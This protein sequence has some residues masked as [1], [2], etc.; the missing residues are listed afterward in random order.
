MSFVLKGDEWSSEVV[1]GDVATSLQMVLGSASMG[2][3]ALDE[4]EDGEDDPDLCDDPVLQVNVH[5]SLHTHCK[6]TRANDLSLHS[7]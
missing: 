3:G 2:M 6:Q 4:E 1:V 7:F 5:V